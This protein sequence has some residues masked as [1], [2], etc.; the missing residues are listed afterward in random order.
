MVADGGLWGPPKWPAPQL[1]PLTQETDCVKVALYVSANTWA[2]IGT[3]RT[4]V[5]AAELLPLTAE[6][7]W[8]TCGVV[9]RSVRV[10]GAARVEVPV[11][12]TV[13]AR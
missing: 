11:G 10:A 3:V 8:E 9:V 12:V 2:G 5:Q 6:A 7:A 13:A 1:F 4:A